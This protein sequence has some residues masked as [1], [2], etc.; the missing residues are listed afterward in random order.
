[1]QRKKQKGFTLVELMLVV[2][3][4]GVLATVA[5]LKFTGRAQ[6]ARITSAKA[7]I[8]GQYGTALQ[9]YEIDCGKYPST[10]EG[11]AALRS[12]SA[13]GWKGPYIKDSNFNDPWGNAYQYR[14]PGT[15]NPD[16]FDLYSFG[17]DGQE[18]GGDDITNWDSGD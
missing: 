13:K 10:E 8:S 11:L 6:D 12:S 9:L 1:M 4:I 3:I 5:V 15:N 18:G 2:V 17:P 7:K 16:D 14:C